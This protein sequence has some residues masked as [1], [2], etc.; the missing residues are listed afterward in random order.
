M[1]DQPIPDAP[2]PVRDA[3]LPPWWIAFA[4]YDGHAVLCIDYRQYVQANGCSHTAPKDYGVGVS[5]DRPLGC[6][7]ERRVGRS[8]N[9]V[10]YT[11][12]EAEALAV[13]QKHADAL[14]RH[15]GQAG[16]EEQE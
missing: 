10:L 15:G 9:A 12:D 5:I 13:W 6:A 2:G 3:N 4:E 14:A 16:R 11:D 8:F 1:T 7:C